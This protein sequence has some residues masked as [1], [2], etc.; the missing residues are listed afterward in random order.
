MPLAYPDHVTSTV[1]SPPDTVQDA[2]IEVKRMLA[3]L[4][5]SVRASSLSG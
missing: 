4:L 2:L 5:Q 1:P 3:A